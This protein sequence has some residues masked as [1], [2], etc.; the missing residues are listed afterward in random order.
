[1]EIREDCGVA[2][3]RNRAAQQRNTSLLAALVVAEAALS[4]GALHVELTADDA[5][6]G[7]AGHAVGAWGHAGLVATGEGCSCLTAVAV[8]DF[9]GSALAVDVAGLLAGTR[10][11][12]ESRAAIAIVHALREARQHRVAQLAARIAASLAGRAVAAGKAETVE[13]GAALREGVADRPLRAESLL[14]AVVDGAVTVDPG[15]PRI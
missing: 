10:L 9:V 14:I 3:R 12:K 8:A 1:M 11:A 6:T 4:R 13:S 5:H 2:Q 15:G 7:L